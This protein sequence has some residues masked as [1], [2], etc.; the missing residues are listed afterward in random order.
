MTV[1]LKIKTKTNLKKNNYQS[2]II[3]LDPIAQVV[4]I[5]GKRQLRL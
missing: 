3:Y 1:F 2:K 5:M 4:W